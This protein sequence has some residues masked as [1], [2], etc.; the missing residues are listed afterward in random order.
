VNTRSLCQYSQQLGDDE[1]PEGVISLSDGLFWYVPSHWVS[2]EA[3]STFA[4]LN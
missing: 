4:L 1:N 3:K 2:G